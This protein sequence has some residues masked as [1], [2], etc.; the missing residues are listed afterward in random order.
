MGVSKIMPNHR[1]LAAKAVSE[2]FERSLVKEF[3]KTCTFHL[4]NTLELDVPRTL[5]NP[6]SIGILSSL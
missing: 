2:I 3:V 1:A 6:H 5:T 4:N